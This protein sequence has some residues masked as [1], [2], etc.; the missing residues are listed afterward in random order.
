MGSKEGQSSLAVKIALAKMPSLGLII[1][2]EATIANHITIA[3]STVS[4]KKQLI[5]NIAV[6]FCNF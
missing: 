3:A 2:Y 1:A 6:V 5:L 4:E